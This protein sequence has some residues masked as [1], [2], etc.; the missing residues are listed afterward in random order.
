MPLGVM[1]H[2]TADMGDGRATSR[3][4]GPEPQHE[5]PV[6]RWGGKSRQKQIQY[7]HRQSW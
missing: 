7:W 1:T 5:D 6:I 4:Y 3:S 2:S